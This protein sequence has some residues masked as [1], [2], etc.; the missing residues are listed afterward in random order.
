MAAKSPA[1]VVD[2]ANNAR[3]KCHHKKCGKKFK[4]GDVRIGRQIGQIYDCDEDS[5]RVI[6]YHVECYA[7]MK[8]T[9]RKRTKR[10]RKAEDIRI[11]TIFQKRPR[12]SLWIYWKSSSPLWSCRSCRSRR[13][14][15][16]T[17]RLHLQPL[18]DHKC[19]TWAS[20]LDVLNK[21]TRCVIRGY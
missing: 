10:I 16:C 18:K 14:H 11:S 21:H 7:A 9:M 1:F 12:K 15:V 4:V 2:C 13:W 17:T 20:W 19:Q 8:K 3:A 5:T 6:F